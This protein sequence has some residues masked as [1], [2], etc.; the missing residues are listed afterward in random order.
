PAA[1][2]ELRTRLFP[3][4]FLCFEC[5]WPSA[6]PANAPHIWPNVREPKSGILGFSLVPLPN[7]K[8][9]GVVPVRPRVFD[10]LPRATDAWQALIQSEPN[11][12]ALA[13]DWKFP[14]RLQRVR[15]PWGHARRYGAPGALIMGDAAHPVSPVGGQGANMSIADGRVLAELILSGER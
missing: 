2:I 3:V 12:A 9:V 10:D 15:R 14:D 7:H 11:L 1:G 4:D 6:L 8:A 13:G 5:Q